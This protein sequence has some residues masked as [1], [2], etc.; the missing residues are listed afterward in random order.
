M[1]RLIFFFQQPLL[2]SSHDPSEIILICWFG[3]QEKVTFYFLFH[4]TFKISCVTTDQHKSW[5]RCSTQH[6]L[7]AFEMIIL[8][9]ILV[10]Q[11]IFH[12]CGMIII[13]LWF[14]CFVYLV[15]LLSEC[16]FISNCLV[17]FFFGVVSNFIS[18]GITIDNI[19]LK[20]YRTLYIHSLPYLSYWQKTVCFSHHQLPMWL[21]QG[22]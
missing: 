17:A 7:D 18:I 21:I 1:E 4:A 19:G 16:C 6:F 5:L 12:L 3:V 10:L 2:Q 13:L 9:L 15:K 22:L 11:S 14:L 20:W 8:L